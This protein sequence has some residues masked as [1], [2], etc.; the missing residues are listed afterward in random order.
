MSLKEQTVVDRLEVLRDGTVQIREANEIIRDGE[1]VSRS[2]HRRVISIEDEN[3]D[4]GG[5]D[6]ASIAVVNA[7][8]STYR[9]ETAKTKKS[10]KG[11]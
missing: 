4:L 10:V 5:M 2:F 1:I 11:R 9:R 8:R 3:P 6:D 7:A